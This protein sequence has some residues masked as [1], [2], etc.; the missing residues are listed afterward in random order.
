MRVAVGILLL[1]ASACLESPPGPGGSGAACIQVDDEF[2][3]SEID[4]AIWSQVLQAGGSIAVDQGA[5]VLDAD[6]DTEFTYLDVHT[7]ESH[8]LTDLRATAEVSVAWEGNADAALVVAGPAGYIGIYVDSGL[9][10]VAVD[11][12]DPFAVL[13]PGDCPAYD[14]VEHRF[15]R[16]R[17]DDGQLHFETSSAGGTFDELVPPQPVPA[18]DHVVLLWA[19]AGAGNRVVSTIRHVFTGCGGG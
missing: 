9:L 18:G 3:G 12:E 7:I 17:E 13:C 2:A 10:G 16:I 6:P 15:W 8:P 4:G 19:E 14:P 1:L 5:L 11:L